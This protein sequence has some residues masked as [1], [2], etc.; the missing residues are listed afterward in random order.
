M[1]NLLFF[2]LVFIANTSFSEQSGLYSNYSQYRETP[3]EQRRSDENGAVEDS[4]RL[5][6][7]E[8]AF[9]KSLSTMHRTLFC[10]HFSVSQRL[11]AM[12][13]A[14]SQYDIG[15]GQA[16]TF[17]PDEAVEMVMKNARENSSVSKRETEGLYSAPNAPKRGDCQINKTFPFQRQ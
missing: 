12:T 2:L 7:Q 5:S 4:S 8:Q 16:Q 9:A 13:L 14:A 11:D 17:T 15:N 10:R 3:K 1:K 6:L